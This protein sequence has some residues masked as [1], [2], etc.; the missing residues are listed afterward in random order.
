MK[1][2]KLILWAVIHSLCVF[3][4]SSLVIL[5]MMNGEKIFGNGNNFS[6]GIAILMLFVLSAVV[7]GSLILVKPL[8]LY[9]D[10][11]KKEAVKLLV[12]TIAALFV[13]TTVAM[14]II[15]LLK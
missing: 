9:L 10:G 12:Y 13:I 6:G 11:L 4:Y 14:L 8:M 2:S 5:L 15:F 3:V 1:N 7:V